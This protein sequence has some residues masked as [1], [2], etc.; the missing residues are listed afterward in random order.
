MLLLLQLFS[1][2]A[3]DTS[4]NGIAFKPD[5]TKMYISG[6]AGDDIN[7]YNLSTAW[8]ISTAVYSQLFSVS[9][10]DTSPRG[11]AFKPDGL[12]MYVTGGSNK[13]NE[14]DLSTAWD[15]S[16][17]SFLQLFTVISG[18]RG[19]FFK[20]DGLTVYITATDY[21][22]VV[23]P[24][25]LSTA[26][27][28]STATQGTMLSVNAQDS[29]P[30]GVFFKPDGSKMYITGEAGAA[31]SEY[32]IGTPT[33]LTFPASVSGNIVAGA[34]GEIVTYDFVTLDGGT[35]VSLTN[36]PANAP[37]STAFGAVGTYIIGRPN[38]S[39]AYAVNATASSLYS[40]S[41]FRNYTTGNT[42]WATN[43]WDDIGTPTSVSGTWR[44]MTEC[45]SNG[46]D[47]NIG[48][49]VRIS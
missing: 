1:V 2:S 25:S 29:T 33:S 28:I 21:S 31:I 45:T 13:I 20:P 5:G 24:Y 46:S 11:I 44:A 18:T 48:L 26:W 7:E 36:G 43:N 23:V 39:T 6:S 15:I 16:T 19:I 9:S 14:Y 38:N 32:D 3:Q 22:G 10:Q 27:D 42:I 8:D 49:W 41:I 40:V 4:P 17:A 34:S 30:T 47:A 35:T 12:K 37:Q